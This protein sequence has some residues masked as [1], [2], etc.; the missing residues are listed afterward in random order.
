M[1]AGR[2]MWAQDQNSGRGPDILAVSPSSVPY[3][4]CARGLTL[5]TLVFSSVR[6]EMTLA[7]LL[8]SKGHSLELG[9]FGPSVCPQRH[10]PCRHGYW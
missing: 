10:G 1:D 6:M 7:G 9:A 5:Q 8:G 2:R 4:F 3:K